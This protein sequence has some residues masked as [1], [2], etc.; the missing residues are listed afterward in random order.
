MHLNFN[1]RIGFVGGTVFG[2]LPNIPSHDLIVTVIMA[3]IGALVSFMASMLFKSIVRIF[4]K[5][6]H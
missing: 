4:K 2:I 1:E 5:P 6:K 3:F